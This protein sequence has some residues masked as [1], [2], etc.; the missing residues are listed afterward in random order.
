MNTSDRIRKA[1]YAAMFAVLL[2]VCSWITVPGAVPFTMQTFGIFCTLLLLGGKLGSCAIFL[3]IALGAIGA[4]VFS[5]FSGGI[6][7]LF[8]TTG[9]YIVGFIFTGLIF[10]GVTRLCGNSLLVKA[11]ALYIGLAVC[12]I[13]GT[14]WFVFL[15]TRSGGAIGFTAA[16]M[17]CVV[18]FIIPD[19]LKLL[20]ALWVSRLLKHAVRLP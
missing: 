1:V 20:L 3:F 15:Y 17:K 12:Y 18:P 16:V 4:P 14:L 5:G 8:G 11:A 13:F 9:G 7:V 19:C 2:A 10:W 6:G